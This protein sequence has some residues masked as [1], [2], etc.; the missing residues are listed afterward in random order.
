LLQK[1][2][3]KAT[4]SVRLDDT[5]IPFGAICYTVPFYPTTHNV[6]VVAFGR[7]GDAPYGGT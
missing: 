4:T 2:S 5:L 3:P 7:L 1:H 6:G